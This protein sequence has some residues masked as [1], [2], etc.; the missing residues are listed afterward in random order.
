MELS[1]GDEGPAAKRRKGMKFDFD[2]DEDTFVDDFL[3]LR[4]A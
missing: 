4:V 1:S 2:F 3:S